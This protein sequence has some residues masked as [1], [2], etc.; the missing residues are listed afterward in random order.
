MW[1]RREEPSVL[2]LV[3]GDSWHGRP[4]APARRHAPP[5]SLNAEITTPSG[6][7]GVFPV[8]A[9]VFFLLPM[10]MY[11]LFAVIMFDFHACVGLL[12]YFRVIML[13]VLFTV[14][15]FDLNAR[16]SFTR[17]AFMDVGWCLI[18]FSIYSVKIKCI[19]NFQC[20]S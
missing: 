4:D 11:S 10:N 20:K 14:I 1:P 7:C 2:R 6:R 8:L 13:C 15:I 5:R 9:K 16:F 18:M 19:L 17:L 3:S 12:F